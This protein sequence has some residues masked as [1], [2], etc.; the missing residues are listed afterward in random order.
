MKFTVLLLIFIPLIATAQRTPERKPY[1]PSN[2][3][4]SLLWQLRLHKQSLHHFEENLY[5]ANYLKQFREKTLNIKNAKPSSALVSL[6]SWDKFGYFKRK[7]LAE[8]I[9][10]IENNALSEQAATAD[11]RVVTAMFRYDGVE[12]VRDYFVQSHEALNVVQN[13]T[14]SER[15]GLFHLILRKRFLESVVLTSAGLY[16]GAMASYMGATELALLFTWL[17]VHAEPLAMIG[18]LTKQD[19]F[20]KSNQRQIEDFL[21]KMEQGKVAEGAWGFQSNQYAINREVVTEF[22]NS[23]ASI[24][25][26]SEALNSQ[27]HLDTRGTYSILLKKLAILKT[28]FEHQGTFQQKREVHQYLT[29]ASDKF[30]VSYDRLLVYDEQLKKPVLYVVI[31]TSLDRDL[32]FQKS[33]QKKQELQMNPNLSGVKAN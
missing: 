31:R 15:S 22:L 13:I 11:K 27:A 8:R 21:K 30:Y 18:Y 16:I 23:N 32:L 2:V 28:A 9:A 26:L 3:C 20:F 12:G 6:N 33:K 24:Q 14:Q 5:L 25:A 1:H 10:G 29:D 19:P 4:A 7:R 17:A